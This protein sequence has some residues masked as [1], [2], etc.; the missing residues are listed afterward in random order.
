MGV[1]NFIVF[2]ATAQC[3]NKSNAMKKILLI[4]AYKDNKKKN[5]T[6]GYYFNNYYLGFEGGVGFSCHCKIIENAGYKMT[7]IYGNMFN[8][9]FFNRSL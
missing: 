2:T 4:C 9:Y 1:E 5:K 8:S 3:F 6:Y 7:G